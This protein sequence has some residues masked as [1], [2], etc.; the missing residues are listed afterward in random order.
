MV[1]LISGEAAS[2]LP[3]LMATLSAPSPEAIASLII[4][5]TGLI[6]AITALLKVIGHQGTIDQ[7]KIDQAANGSGNG[8]HAPV[9]IV[10]IKPVN[11]G[12]PA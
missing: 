10:P 1:A 7:A 2:Y 11:G 9:P 5:I 6:T 3:Y 12:Q 8:T 4:A